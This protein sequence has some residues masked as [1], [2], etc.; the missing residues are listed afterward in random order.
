MRNGIM[1]FALAASLIALLLA[2]GA[3]TAR[4]DTFSVSD[5]VFDPAN[6][7]AQIFI[8]GIGGGEA[9]W[10]RETT[11]GNPDE[12]IG[13]TLIPYPESYVGVLFH[14]LGVAFDPSVDG[15][16][17]S[18]DY[19]ED[20]I[21]T[22]GE[23][24][25]MESW[26]LVFQDGMTFAAA[27]FM[28]TETEWTTKSRL[29]LRAEDFGWLDENLVLHPETNPDFSPNGT[30]IEF[31]FLRAIATETSI[32]RVAGIDNWSFAVHPTDAIGYCGP[33]EVNRGCGARADVLFLNGE[34][35]GETRR[36]EATTTTPLAGTIIEP[37]ANLGDGRDTKACVYAWIGTPG[38]GDIVTVPKGLGTMCYGPYI[39]ATKA[40]KKIWNGI[41]SPEKLGTHTGPGAPPLI[42]DGE[43]FTFLSVPGGLGRTVTVTFQ[44]LVEDYCSMGSVAFS[45]TNG[46][47]LHVQ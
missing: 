18:I 10:S 42:V 23:A 34:S 36:I 41:G 38:N 46:F 8:V 1:S 43:A 47:T 37:P 32:L 26:P 9:Y 35:G 24:E 13:V 29:G 15:P 5:G 39:I 16:I 3:P 22:E 21:L 33:G 30:A 40:P 44:G 25:G 12:Y 7:D 45:V 28:V 11:G 14:R 31:G 4:A 27:P 17:G 6:W 20:A 19:A 2:G